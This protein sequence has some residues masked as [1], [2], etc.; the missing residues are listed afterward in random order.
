MKG[1]TKFQAANTNHNPC[2]DHNPSQ[3]SD[4]M[5]TEHGVRKGI[6]MVNANTYISSAL[7]KCKTREIL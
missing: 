6:K 5:E 1:A 7:G 3:L 4:R 2:N